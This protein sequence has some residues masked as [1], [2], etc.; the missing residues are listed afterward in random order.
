MTKKTAGVDPFYKTPKEL[1]EAVD[2]YFENPETETLYIEGQP[3]E[4]P[5]LT[6]T[7]LALRLGFCSRQSF[8]DYEK[9]DKFSY[10]IKRARTFIE[11]NY[12]KLLQKNN[13]TGAI[14]ALKN[15]GWKDKSE[16]DTNVNL[17][18]S[19]Q[20]LDELE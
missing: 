17:T 3:H 2:E 9:R 7:G 12:E 18:T 19:E 4:V 16:V 11:N 8:Y 10:T 14:F 15:L 1:Q 13:V 6:I 5:I 20:W